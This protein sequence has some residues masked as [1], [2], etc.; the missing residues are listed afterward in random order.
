MIADDH[1]PEDWIF[2]PIFGGVFIL[3]VIAKTLVRGILNPFLLMA[4]QTNSN[5]L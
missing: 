5:V 3:V 1:T 4:S 2:D